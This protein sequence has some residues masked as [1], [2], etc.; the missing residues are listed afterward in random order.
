MRSLLKNVLLIAG[1][2]AAVGCSRAMADVVIVDTVLTGD[3][4]QTTDG[5]VVRIKGV[6]LPE[7]DSVAVEWLRKWIEKRAAILNSGGF[8]GEIRDG[9]LITFVFAA[10]HDDG[11]DIG[12]LLIS[13]GLAL[14]DVSTAGE[15]L[16]DYLE[17]E[18]EARLA[19]RGVWSGGP[20]PPDTALSWD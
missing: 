4:F 6:A 17:R 5:R 12:G 16:F 18:D 7:N 15:R 8:P 3:S 1:C 13:E 9:V 10:P 20:S 14:C 2:V 19:K 11:E